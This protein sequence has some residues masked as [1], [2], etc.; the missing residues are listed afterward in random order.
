MRTK[1]WSLSLSVALS[2]IVLHSLAYAESKTLSIDEVVKS[3]LDASPTVLQIEG[4]FSSRRADAFEAKT[5]SNP[6][7][8]AE[9][10]VPVASKDAMGDKEVSVSLSQPIKMSHGE[11]RDRLADLLEQVGSSEKEQAVLELV[12]KTRIAFAR[13]WLLSER[14]KVLQEVQPKTK[15]LTQFVSSGLKQGAYGKGDEAVFRTEVAKTEA[16]L[17]GIQAEK[18]AAEA[19][20][21]R[22]TGSSFEGVTLS[23]P[24]LFSSIPV[25]KVEM[26]LSQGELKVQRR[27]KILVN[28]ARADSAV[29]KRDAFPEL[30]PKLFYSR[31][32]E[33]V[34]LVGIGLSFDLPFYSQNTAEQMRKTSEVLTAESQATFF[35]GEAFRSSVLKSVRMYD[36]RR[37]EV[38]LYEQKVI[39]S[40]KEALRAFE[41]Q[42]RGGEGS[43]FQLWQT[44]REYLEIQERYLD[45]WTSAFTEYLE[46]SILFGQEL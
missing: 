18:L 12:T 34:D 30:R 33:G 22:L 40:I 11:L 32:N 21:A 24:G 7:L 41:A 46:L 2:T 23:N 36:L 31:T 45:L 20:L 35:Q 19:E 43:V 28:L 25:S 14:E 16:E 3:A 4:A 37:Q 10:G 27:A 8:E 1:Y 42:V 9:F 17:L 13:Q 26:L 6:S 5:L 15:S 39:P 29:A 44:L 38:L